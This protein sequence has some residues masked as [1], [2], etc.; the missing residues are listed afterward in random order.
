MAV[1][2]EPNSRLYHINIVSTLLLVIWT[3]WKSSSDQSHFV[4]KV[5]QWVLRKKYWW[6]R[7]TRQDYAIYLFN[8]ILKIVLLVPLFDFSFAIARGLSRFLYTHVSENTLLETNPSFL[9][10]FLFTLS[11]FVWDDFLRFFHH[12]L[13]HKIPFLWNFHKTHHSARVLTPF[14]LFR[15]HPVE[16]ALA[17]LRNSISLG[18]ASGFF[19]F[20][21]GGALSLWTILG[22]N[23]FGFI[24]NFFGA[25]LRHSHIPMGFG[26]LEKFLISPLQHQIHHSKD[27]RHYDKN[28]GVSLAIWD[29]W[30][31]TH[32]YSSPNLNLKFGLNE[33]LPRR[34]LE[35]ITISQLKS[36][37]LTGTR[38]ERS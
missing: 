20:I 29:F 38:P 1:F 28:F 34:F 36:S 18:V 8:V 30:W 19:V 5:R 6:N 17:V 35:L 37:G 23:A 31:G 4:K 7:S 14:T 15:T 26:P 25:N 11:V 22:V 10:M 27:K 33:R 16:S 12:W 24:F 32:V 9:W 13:M 2:D 21:F 3:A